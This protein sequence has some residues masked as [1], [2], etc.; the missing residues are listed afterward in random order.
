MNIWKQR[1]TKSDCTAPLILSEA[2]GF[3]D[4]EDV[5]LMNGWE[6]CLIAES[7]L[8]DLSDVLSSQL[9]IS[10]HFSRKNADISTFPT[11][12]CLTQSLWQMFIKDL[13]LLFF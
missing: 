7:T 5:F 9:F 4:K 8:A 6:I 11:A 2:K 13:K 12:L 10:G 1:Q 3:L